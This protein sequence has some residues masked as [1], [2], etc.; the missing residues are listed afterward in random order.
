METGAGKKI[1]LGADR[2][3]LGPA[4]LG[5]SIRHHGW[6]MRIDPTARLVWPVYPFNPYG[7]ASETSLEWAVGALSVD[8]HPSKPADPAIRHR[9]QEIDFVISVGDRQ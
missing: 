5:G 4:D 2:I 7:N 3:E 6:T 8:L 9:A 1:T